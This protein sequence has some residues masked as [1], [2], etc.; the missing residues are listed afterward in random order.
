M[1]SDVQRRHSYGVYISRLIRFSR[2]CAYVDVVNARNK[3]L[4]AGLLK[5]VIGSIS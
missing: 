3:C 1:M 4:T 2:V 5:M